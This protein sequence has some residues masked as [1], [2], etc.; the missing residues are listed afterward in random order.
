M[1]R[2]KKPT[3]EELIAKYFN[4]NCLPVEE[5]VEKMEGIRKGTFRFIEFFSPKATIDGGMIFKR[6]KTEIQAKVDHTHTKNYEEPTFHRNEDSTYIV[7]NAIKFNNVTKNYLMTIVPLWDTYE[8][9]YV[10]GEGNAIEKEVA[11]KMLKPSAPRKDGKLPSML[12]PRAYMVA[13]IH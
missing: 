6:A 8:T 5:V 12:T 4:I 1:A 9:E 11:E 7:E 13:D 10:D 3:T 2:T